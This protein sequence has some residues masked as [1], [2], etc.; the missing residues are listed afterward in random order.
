MTSLN[1]HQNLFVWRE[2]EG[3][4]IDCEINLDEL[5]ETK[6]G[7]KK[8]D[9]KWKDFLASDPFNKKIYEEKGN[10]LKYKSEQLIPLKKDKR[11]PL[12]LVL[13]NPATHSVEN[14]MF[15][16]F[17]GNKKEHR[18]WKS[19][20]KPAGVLNLPFDSNQA[21]T[22]L[23]KQRREALFNLK[24]DSPFRIGL[25]VFITMP[26]APGG[27]W[28]GIAGVHKLLGIR[29]LRLLEQAETERVL[30]C[31]NKFVTPKGKVLIFQKNAWNALRSDDDPL[32]GID[33]AKAGKLKGTLK[34]N[35]KLPLFCVPPTR[36]SGPCSNV[37]NKFI[38]PKLGN[39]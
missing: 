22:K 5:F 14:G 33:M 6:E 15:F 27:K 9:A 2:S 30:D 39:E 11:P 34:D 35:P 31:A 20:L 36:L 24:Y 38:F 18:F 7:R 10:L 3:C 17:E 8:F 19:I 21:V 16:S 1:K 26:S 13:G 37:L 4:T 32:Y 28:G 25:C 12:L 29:A 23:N